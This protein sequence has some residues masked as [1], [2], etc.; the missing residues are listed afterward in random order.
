MK[1]LTLGATD[2]TDPITLTAV[3]TPN[4]YNVTLDTNGGTIREGNVTEYT[5]GVGAP[6]PTKPE[7]RPADRR[8]WKKPCWAH[9]T[10]C[11][12]TG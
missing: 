4:V 1:E 2:Y 10:K 8:P 5:Y 3:W 12:Q 7:I 6:L 11:P 9:G